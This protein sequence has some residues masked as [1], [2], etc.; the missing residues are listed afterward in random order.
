MWALHFPTVFL[1]ALTVQVAAAQS[2]W[3]GRWEGFSFV[4][5][6]AE[7]FS[8]VLELE[9]HGTDFS[10]TAL[11]RS[12]DGRLTARFAMIGKLKGDTLILQEWRQIEPSAPRWC[13]KRCKLLLEE[14]D[15][16]RTLRGN[17]SAEGCPDGILELRPAGSST[18]AW[19]MA[20]LS[21]RWT[22][23]LGQSDRDYGFYF[24]LHLLPDGTGY[25]LIESEGQGGL[26][27]MDLEW[28]FEE[29][30]T[31]FHFKELHTQH[32]SDANWPW[33][34]KEAELSVSG[35]ASVRRMEG[36]WAGYI[37]GHTGPK[38]ACAPG[39]LMVEQVRA[40]TRETSGLSDELD[41]YEAER[42]RVVR[43][44]RVVQVSR[45]ELK[46]RVWDNGV[47]DGDVLTLYLNEELLL[48][49]FRVTKRKH[50]L[51]VR[52]Q[53]A[54]NVLIMHADDLG[55]ISPN[56]VAISIDDG[57]GEQILIV[58]SNLDESGAVLVRWFE[59]D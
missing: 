7:R 21:G 50:T 24:E 18:A 12:P 25:S 27:R 35:D 16:Q 52:L 41:S 3:S 6:K 31:I 57:T 34:L 51:N 10:G 28:R 42:E 29:A 22:G 32:R 9:Q 38:G 54:E 8:Y 56:T 46:I 44:G 5:G 19:P 58:S 48:K 15:G 26:A 43:M 14:R 1:L 40:E 30:R 33:C 55:S 23:H 37:E 17:W 59:V 11:S 13:L 20:N 4:P 39:H 53:Q 49:R 2:I 47:E 45:P 36:A